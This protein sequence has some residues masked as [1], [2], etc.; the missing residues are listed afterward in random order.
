MSGTNVLDKS[1]GSPSALKDMRFTRSR[2]LSGSHFDTPTAAQRVSFLH[3]NSPKIQLKEPASNESRGTQGRVPLWNYGASPF[4][5]DQTSPGHFLG[6][7]TEKLLG[8]SLFQGSP[9]NSNNPMNGGFEKTG[10]D[11]TESLFQKPTEV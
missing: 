4:T 7:S 6:R 3:L 9:M 5:K 1:R 8:S 11:S 2:A 10:Q